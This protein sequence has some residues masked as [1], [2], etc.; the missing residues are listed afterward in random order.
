MSAQQTDQC[1][2]ETNGG[3]NGHIQ[4]PAC[5][6]CL[7]LAHVRFPANSHVPEAA[8]ILPPERKKRSLFNL[9]GLRTVRQRSQ[10]TTDAEAGNSDSEDGPSSTASS[11]ADRKKKKKEEEWDEELLGPK[12][13]RP[14]SGADGIAVLLFGVCLPFW[15][16][17]CCLS[18]I[19]HR[20][21][22]VI[23][24]HPVETLTELALV[25]LIP[26]INA[27]AWA[28]LCKHKV[29][30]CRLA[31]LL[32]GAAA[33]T[34]LVVAGASIAV[35]F[36]AAS[37]FSTAS[38]DTEYFSGMAWLAAFALLA[39]VVSSYLLHRIRVSRD[40]GSS[41]KQVVFSS[42]AGAC[43]AV[44][45]FGLSEARPWMVRVAESQA[46][47][48]NQ[49]RSEAGLALLRSLR[50]ERELH[51]ECADPRAAGLAGLFIPIKQSNL[52]KLYFALTGQPYS[53]HETKNVDLSSMPD[54]YL[55][56]N[57]VGELVPGLSAARSTFWAE[58]HPKTSTATLSCTLVLKNDTQQ[59]Q[60]AR[61]EM[62]LPPG[63]VITNLTS[64]RH[65]STFDASFVATEGVAGTSDTT[66]IGHD[67][68]ATISDLGRG[69][70]LMHCYPVNSDEE[71]KVRVTMAVPLKPNN[72][73]TGTLTL[74]QF[75]ASNF[76]LT[77][78]HQLSVSSSD[79][80]LS[81][82][83]R[84]E[85]SQQRD[86]GYQLNGTLSADDLS[87]GNVVIQAQREISK[88]PIAVLDA[89]AVKMAA[90]AE[91]RR[92][93]ELKLKLQQQAQSSHDQVVLMVDGSKLIQNQIDLVRRA[94]SARRSTRDVPKAHPVAPRYVVQTIE[95]IAAPLPD[96]LLVVVDGSQTT[97]SY[98]PQITTA[99]SKLPANIPAL[100]TV[101]G[102]DGK[103]FATPESLSEGLKDLSKFSF[104]GGKDNLKAVVDA[105]RL[106]GQAKHGA[107][108]WIHGPQ[109]EM[110]QE[111]YIVSP[112]AA[113]PAFYELPLGSAATNSSALFRNHPE[114]GPFE[115]VPCNSDKV[116]EALSTFI[117]GWQPNNSTFVMQLAETTEKPQEAAKLSK[118]EEGELLAL[119]ARR[120]T[121]ELIQDKHRDRATAVAVRYNIVSPVSRALVN[122]DDQSNA[123]LHEQV[124][125]TAKNSLDA[126]MIFG[127]VP[128]RQT[129]KQSFS[130][131]VYQLNALNNYSAPTLQGATNGTIGPQGADATVIT[132]VNTAGTVRVNNLANL[133]AMLNITANLGEIVLLALGAIIAISGLFDSKCIVFEAFGEEIEISRV[134]R[135]AAGFL[136]AGA[137]LFIPGMINWLVA[138]AR[139]ANLFS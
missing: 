97:A 26:T 124:T 70:V 112:Y 122:E 86:G 114:I 29:K 95:K 108:L 35:M 4:L 34:G 67:S 49:A 15:L 73:Q 25:I 11:N 71:Y 115:Q 77:G 131:V 43:M 60:E 93:E 84:F 30:F 113:Q 110:N 91:A 21:S 105:A 116:G 127:W 17:F 82:L 78:E 24:N 79:H 129:L 87:S 54:D 18:S 5:S 38:N 1:Q 42:V 137:G 123:D 68:P 39:A 85:I 134:H 121:Q 136:L 126:N 27:V 50:P 65:G 8:P 94:M 33:A 14:W 13:R 7:A 133:E 57:V 117:S 104:V 132:G 107:V 31:S 90:E 59:P 58:I 12:P 20:L 6:C 47:D 102:A 40:F 51:M 3:N 52:H 56:R 111:I 32:L 22:L 83:H 46:T 103:H 64:W 72:L 61:T 80:L 120:L 44:V 28:A 48:R 2:P 138:S 23:L 101:A 139:D 53:F 16:L 62:L 130:T 37:P 92:V 125:A 81:P 98:L 135:I 19:P 119:N 10:S 41:R 88:S 55:S 9:L 76:A 75:V 96:K 128:F 45:M 99:L 89:L 63:A 74:P 109:P 36:A 106:A 100:L 69:R 66:S 118:S